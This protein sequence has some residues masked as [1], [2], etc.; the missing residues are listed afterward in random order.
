MTIWFIEWD[1]NF[2]ASTAKW[3]HFCA[4]PTDVVLTPSIWPQIVLSSWA[5][6]SRIYRRSSVERKLCTRTQL[7]LRPFTHFFR[8][9]FVFYRQQGCSWTSAFFLFFVVFR[10][11]VSFSPSISWH[12]THSIRFWITNFGFNLFGLFVPNSWTSHTFCCSL[13]DLSSNQLAIRFETKRT[14]LTCNQHFFVFYLWFSNILF[15]SGLNVF[16]FEFI[17]LKKWIFKWIN[18][19]LYKPLCGVSM[20]LLDHFSINSGIEKLIV[21]YIELYFDRGLRFFFFVSI[22]LW[23]SNSKCYALYRRPAAGPRAPVIITSSSDLQSCLGITSSPFSVAFGPAPVRWSC[24][25][26]SRSSRGQCDQCRPDA[27]PTF[28]GILPIQCKSFC[29]LII[30]CFQSRLL[31]FFSLTLSFVNHRATG[32]SRFQYQ[33]FPGALIVCVNM[34]RRPPLSCSGNQTRL[35]AFSLSFI[36]S[37]RT[38]TCHRHQ[39]SFFFC[40]PLPTFLPDHIRTFVNLFLMLIICY[41]WTTR[42]K[43]ASFLRFITSVCRSTCHFH[44]QP[45]P[46]LS[47]CLPYLLARPAVQFTRCSRP[48]FD[49]VRPFPLPISIHGECQSSPFSLLTLF[50]SFISYILHFFLFFCLFCCW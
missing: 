5:T 17:N 3:P 38:V 13:F 21:L 45:F 6:S 33:H 18:L 2:F 4:M 7:E 47:C 39:I 31:L 8:S 12:S 30:P 19:F 10:C 40:P 50:L 49:W 32:H 16:F 1:E 44:R 22:I 34:S 26:V 15:E 9:F 28:T 37:L 24:L 20:C 35:D 27:C 41:C 29:L 25:L 23:I 43:K 42:S 36:F 14:S 46:K 48:E 11:F